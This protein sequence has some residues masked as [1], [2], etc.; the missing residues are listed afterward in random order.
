MSQR[1]IVI[2]DG[3]VLDSNA[4]RARDIQRSVALR[5]LPQSAEEAFGC[6]S[7]E[8]DR[9]AV[10]HPQRIAREYAQL[11]QLLSARGAGQLGL[12]AGAICDARGRERAEQAARRGRRAQ[13][14]AE[15]HEPLIEIARGRDERTGTFPQRALTSGRLDVVLDAGDTSEHAR[16]VAVDERRAFTERDRR[17]RTCGVRPDAGNLA[18]F[19]RAL[20]QLAVPLRGDRFGALLEIARARVVAEAGPRGEHVVERRIGKRAYRRKPRHPAL[21]VRNHRLHPRLLQHDLAD[22]DRVWIARPS[23]RQV[24]LDRRVVSDDGGPERGVLHGLLV[25]QL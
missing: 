15:L 12:S 3:R 24:A 4:E 20:R 10:A 18:Q 16:D 8:H 21:P 13:R 1:L 17:D 11:V 14:R 7:P 5:Q 2:R 19:A 23:P 25:P 6:A 22:P 9:V